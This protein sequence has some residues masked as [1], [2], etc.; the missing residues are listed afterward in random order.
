LD[1][2]QAELRRPPRQQRGL[3][4]S[5]SFSGALP[6]RRAARLI[7]GGTVR[8][9]IVIAGVALVLVSWGPAF[10]QELGTFRWQLAPH[11]NVITVN[12]ERK[13]S[14]YEL[15]GSDDRCGQEPPAT[16][17]GVAL[18]LNERVVTLGMLAT[19]RDGTPSGLSATMFVST[20][21]GFWSDGNGN[22]GDVLFN[23]V[24]PASGTPRTAMVTTFRG[25]FAT[26]FTAAFHR[27]MGLAAFSFPKYLAVAMPGLQE[28]VR[29]PGSSPTA[30]CPGSASD[31]QAAPGHLCVYEGVSTNVF[32]VCVGGGANCGLT[33]RSGAIVHVTAAAPGPVVSTGTWAVTLVP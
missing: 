8:I 19:G 30:S 14:L 25:S 4:R 10:A 6:H 33:D 1:Y 27:D 26:R 13:G 15:A 2:R 23:P 17:H 31:P 16:L 32:S 7:D 3:Q 12:V 28:D 20:L 11:C 5:I 9:R 21:S 18:Q 24:L 29:P 22:G